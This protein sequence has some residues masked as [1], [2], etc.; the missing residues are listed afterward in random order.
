MKREEI[1][2][3]RDMRF[4]VCVIEGELLTGNGHTG[5][6]AIIT[7][8][9]WQLHRINCV[10]ICPLSSD[11]VSGLCDYKMGCVYVDQGHRSTASQNQ[12]EATALNLFGNPSHNL[13]IRRG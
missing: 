12:Q 2:W 7:P 3:Q 8:L 5:L 10:L 11:S 4:E 13:T 1:S 9:I 6:M